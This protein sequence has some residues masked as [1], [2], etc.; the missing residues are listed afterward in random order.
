M[1]ALQNMTLYRG[2]PLDFLDNYNS[3]SPS[4][5][6]AREIGPGARKSNVSASEH[7]IFR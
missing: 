5:E 6:L 3:T 2:N 7:S 4:L 1:E